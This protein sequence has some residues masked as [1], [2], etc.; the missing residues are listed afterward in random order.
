MYVVDS[1]LRSLLQA[2]LLLNALLL[3]GLTWKV[4]FK[5]HDKVNGVLYNIQ[6]YLTNNITTYHHTNIQL[7]ED[8]FC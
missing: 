8:I 3:P 2:N 7:G 6:Y 4:I 1:C 5:N